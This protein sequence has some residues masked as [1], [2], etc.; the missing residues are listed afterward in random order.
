VLDVDLEVVLKVLA[1]ARKPVDDI[2]ADRPQVRGLA[3]SRQLE[4]LRRVD[5]ASAEDH[6]TARD[7]L[8][9]PA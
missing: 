5:R 8:N 1:D 3:D 7:P 2:D 9:P 4:E 6:L